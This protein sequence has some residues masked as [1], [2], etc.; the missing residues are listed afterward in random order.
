MMTSPNKSHPL[1][2]ALSGP[3]SSG[4]TTIATALSSILPT[5]LTIHAD[6]FYKADSQI[7]VVDGLQDWDCAGSLDLE[8]VRSVLLKVRN[9]REDELEGL[10]RQGNYEGGLDGVHGVKGIEDAVVQRLRNEVETWPEVHKKRKI[11]VVDGFLLF[12]A[13]VR[14]QLAGLFDVRVLL[15]TRYEDAKRRRESRSGY[16]TLE[17]F[18]EDPEG[19]FDRIVWPNYVREHGFLFERG[20]GEGEVEG[21]GF[22]DGV[23]L[24]SVNESLEETL[25]WVVGVISKGLMS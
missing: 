6:D 7:P 25:E 24:G 15:R 12:G 10:V 16:V 2:L 18:W 5:H 9:G 11:I 3:T 19:Y 21:H 14:E 4:K 17:G 8:K 20:N 23:M 13:S 22:V 1:L